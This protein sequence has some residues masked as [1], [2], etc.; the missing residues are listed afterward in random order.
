[1]VVLACRWKQRWRDVL[2]PCV[3]ESLAGVPIKSVACG[4][5]DWH[6]TGH[7]AAVALDGQVSAITTFSLQCTFVCIVLAKRHITDIVI[8]W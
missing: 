4:S 8:R 1:M 2:V 3:V 7:F 6:G 5:C